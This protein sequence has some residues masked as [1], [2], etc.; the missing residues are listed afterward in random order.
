M[1]QN[2]KLK[3]IPMEIVF[4]LSHYQWCCKECAVCAICTGQPLKKEGH[5]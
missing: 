3:T 2:E 5:L 4:H 1:E